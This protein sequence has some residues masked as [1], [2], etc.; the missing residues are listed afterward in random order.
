MRIK[1]SL[2][3]V[4]NYLHLVPFDRIIKCYYLLE[5]TSR[6]V[7]LISLLLCLSIA[8]YA[9]NGRPFIT[10]FPPS[11]YASNDYATSPQNWC[12]GEDNYGRIVVA[13]TSGILVYDGSD[14][15]LVSGTENKRML[16]FAKDK[17]GVLYTGGDAELGFIKSNKEGELEYQSLLEKLPEEFRTFNSV[18]NVVS[19]KGA[20]YFRSENHV[21]RYENG[22][23]KVW[24]SSEGFLKLVSNSSGLYVSEKDT[25]YRLSNDTLEVIAASN[26]QRLPDMTAIYEGI[27]DTL[28]IATRNQGIVKLIRGEVIFSENNLSASILIMNGCVISNGSFAFATNGYGVIIVDRHGEVIKVIDESM[29]LGSNI[30]YFPFYTNGSL[31][32]AASSGISLIEY[33]MRISSLDKSDGLKGFPTRVSNWQDGL[34]IGAHEGA[35]QVSTNLL[36]KKGELTPVQENLREIFGLIELKNQLVVSNSQG[37]LVLN[38]DESNFTVN[39]VEGKYC[40]ALLPISKRENN[41]YAAFSNQIIPIEINSS[42]GEK[43][44]DPITCPHDVYY[45]TEDEYGNLWAADNGISYIN[46]SK[47]YDNPKILTLTKKHGLVPEMGYIQVSSV[48]DQVLI[49]TE[50]GVYTFDHKK[51]KLVPFKSFGKNFSDGSTGVYNITETRNGDVWVTTDRQTGLLRKQSNGT[52]VY[53][54]LALIRAPISDVWDIYED[55]DGIVWIAGTEAIVRYDPS[56]DFN[57]KTPYKAFI[58]NVVVNDEKVLFKGYHADK[59]GNL[60]SKQPKDKIPVLPYEENSI[61]FQ[62]GAAYYAKDQKLEYS[63]K[64]VGKDKKWSSWR[65]SGQMSYNNLPEG[66]YTFKVRSKNVYGN[67][68]EE[69]SYTFEILP[70]WYRTTWAYIGFGVGGVLFLFILLK[71]N[72]AR[73]RRENLKLEGIITERTAEVRQ[74][75]ER[76]EQS[77]AFKQQFLANMSHEIRTPMNAVMGMTNLVL[78]TPLQP[79]QKN[80]MEGIQKS[81]DNLL[82]IINDIL[83]LSKIEAGKMELEEIDF[84][85]SDM[86]KQV[87]QTLQHRASDKGLELITSID[88]KVNDIV[89]GDPVRLNQVLINLT[90]NAIKFTEKGSVSIEITQSI[91]KVKFAIVD[92]G[93]GIPKDKLATVFESFSQA[94]ASDTRKFGGTGLGLSISRQLV[95]LMGGTISV[96]SEVGYGTTFFFEIELREGSEEALEQ[97]MAMEHD[98]DGTI[99][100]GLRILVTDDNTFNRVVAR[101][102]LLENADVTIIEAE[103]GQEAIDVLLEKEIDVILM[104]VQ[105]PVMN[106]FESTRAIRKLDGPKKDTPIIALTASVLRTDLDKCKDA[107]MDSYI[108]KPFKR[109]D[110][111]AGIAEV[112]NIELRSSKTKSK[113]AKSSSQTKSGVTDLE[114]LTNFCKGDRSK[115]KKYIDMFLK[116][117]Q[118]LEEQ[119]TT[120][121]AEEDSEA[122]ANQ[123][124]SFNTKFIMMG[125]KETKSL[126]VAIENE[127]RA[128]GKVEEVSEKL[129]F[130]RA[131]IKSAVQELREFEAN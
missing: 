26:E 54:S 117:A 81:S 92:T 22:A 127:L 37:L 82:H 96:E 27:G 9:Q 91:G 21:Y 40:S 52:F 116:G 15:E 55:N 122:I 110:L 102:T 88:S 121:L 76:A 10:N 30:S 94:N 71:L 57:Y 99:L 32:V 128:G 74:Q 51:Q 85:L 105:M 80:Y 48:N 104:D 17:D 119:L 44:S 62:F 129:E 73:L 14:W 126:S 18:V 23:F 8:A 56:V 70:P 130:L 120:S 69:A 50:I 13:N 39:G 53:D 47:G 67:I 90:G 16:K 3:E 79:K 64:L 43:L 125:M 7:Y 42:S 12:I 35:F 111:I 87:H 2:N 95:G 19:Y 34:F 123:V 77:E 49:A 59:N 115:M 103:N 63:V 114:Y 112:L 106:G 97:R 101:D 33:P 65:T 1:Q 75:K 72:S 31:W 41:I 109:H 11:D 131:D 61:T 84:S 24:K 100:D 68:S 66:R 86:V 45:L 28:L 118:A 78:N 4:F 6:S 124:H 46:L 38:K 93:V 58:R 113:A 60:L 25:W 108:P 107:G 29:G 5:R 89:L 20:V 36:T 98:V 83:D